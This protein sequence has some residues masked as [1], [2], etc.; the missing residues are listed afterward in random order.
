MKK[1]FFLTVLLVAGSVSAEVLHIECSVYGLPVGAQFTDSEEIPYQTIVSGDFTVD[2]E[3]VFA[4]PDFLDII[5]WHDET[6]SRL[7]KKTIP[8]S[9][10]GMKKSSLFGEPYGT[11]LQ[12]HAFQCG[13][14]VEV[15]EQLS[16]DTD[17]REIKRRPLVAEESDQQSVVGTDG[18]DS[19]QPSPPAEFTYSL[20]FNQ[21]IIINGL[22]VIGEIPKDRRYTPGNPSFN[23]LT[24]DFPELV[25]APS[26]EDLLLEQEPIHLPEGS[27]KFVASDCKVVQEIHR[28][29]PA[30][31]D[32]DIPEGLED[33]PSQP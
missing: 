7:I 32:R 16:A 1:I 12:I 20:Y 5:S 22:S 31:Q 29:I 10:A 28:D 25:S 17:I 3:E 6:V 14:P 23:E 9:A 33:P 24:V 27:F 26:P 18:G 11:R 8:C 21:K 15:S 13:F 2:T 4:R 19:S 30:D